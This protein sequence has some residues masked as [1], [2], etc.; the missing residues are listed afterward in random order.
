MI[1][2]QVPS[3]RTFN[4]DDIFLL[5]LMVKYGFIRMSEKPFTL[6]SGIESYVYVYGREDITDNP[7]FEWEIGVKIAN[8]VRENSKPEDKKPYLIGIPTAGTAF[9]QAAALA[10]YVNEITVNEWYIRHRLMKEA[11]KKHGAHQNWVNGEA[12]PDHTYWIIDNVV[13]DGASKFEANE[14]LRESGY[15]VDDMPSIVFVDR[16]QGGIQKM[17]AGGF[18]RIIVAYELL[19]LTFAFGELKLWPKNMVKAVEEE[20]SAHQFV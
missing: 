20:I 2:M 19:D 5:R 1:T 9:A 12:D 14:R 4:A 6:K 8:L 3:G 11:L 17:K 16:Q 18:K 15:P 10:S 13:T 7:D